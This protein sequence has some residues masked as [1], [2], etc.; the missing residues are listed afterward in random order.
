MGRIIGAF[1][2][3]HPPLMVPEVGQGRERE[4]NKTYLASK[5]AGQEIFQLKPDTVIITSP[6]G[7]FFSDFFYMPS[8]ETLKGDMSNFYAPE[9]AIEFKN[10][11]RLGSEIIE[12]ASED[13]FKVGDLEK[14]MLTR[15]GLD[16]EMDHGTFVPLYFVDKAYGDFKKPRIVRI[17]VA[18][19][20]LKRL[21]QFGMAIKKG[22]EAS[23]RKAVFIASGD[24]SHCLIPGAPAGYDPYGATYD[25]MI[26][27]LM[28]KGDVQGLITIKP[29]EMARAKE[30]GTRSFA[31]MLGAL[32]KNIKATE[33]YSY[34]GP[35]GVGYMV[36]RIDTMPENG[37]VKLAREA[38]EKYVK[39]KKILKA[40]ADDSFNFKAG[41]F[42]SIKKDGALRGCI[43]TIYPVRG[44]VA[45][46]VIYNAISAGTRDSRF[47]P[48][49]TD[50]LGRLRYS[51]DVLTKPEPIK[52]LDLLDV[53]RY[54]VIVTAGSKK[55]VLLPDLEGVDTVLRQVAIAL[56]KAGIG[57]G[58]EYTVER[59][60]VIR[61]G[62]K[63]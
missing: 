25:R 44:N 59:F 58:E 33:V 12:K 37:Y 24:M 57:E 50:E 9:A 34:E 32:D 62:A 51:V 13:G 40:P 5:R 2:F 1:I 54:G 29:G 49:T 46:E 27:D 28:E 56:E 61:H 35:F 63:E 43:G 60:E 55:G 47:E 22:V 15:L 17:S 20:P 3:P 14:K 26:V 30:C 31:I 45:E 23:G 8:I 41:V 36:G 42:V 4:V 11:T 53:K 39:N 6:H 18:D 21:Y 52:N 10:D 38:L 19:M 48:I 16:T 7:P